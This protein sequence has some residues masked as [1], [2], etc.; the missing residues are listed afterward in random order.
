[1]GARRLE[2]SARRA[3]DRLHDQVG[4][5]GLVAAA[6]VPGLAAVVDQHAAAVRDILTTGI[7][8]GAVVAG[9]VLLAGYAQGIQDHL[10]ERGLA[11]HIPTD[12]ADWR[13]AS[14]FHVRLLAVCSLAKTLRPGHPVASADNLPSLT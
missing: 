5:A 8:S 12:A 11:L 4:T 6:T 14:W 7:E 9:A 10:R 1:M 13:T 3:L 2:R